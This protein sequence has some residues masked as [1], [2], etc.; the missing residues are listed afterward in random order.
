MFTLFV[1][2]L[3]DKAA[4]SVKAAIYFIDT[5]LYRNV[6]STEHCDLIQDTLSNM[7]DWSQRSNIRFNTSKF[8][9]L[10]VTRKKALTGFDCTLDGTTWTRVS[11]EKDLGVIITN[12]LSWDSHIHTIT[13]KANKLLGLLKRTCPL[14]TDVSVGRSLYFLWSSHSCFTSPKSGRPLTLL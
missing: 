3:S 13:A 2:D 14:L 7:H 8:K 11:E 6:S 4:D 12:T 5:K 10:T 1:N 9:A